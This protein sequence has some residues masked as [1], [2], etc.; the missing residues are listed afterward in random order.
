[1]GTLKGWISQRYFTVQTTLLWTGILIMILGWLMG[2]TPDFT[3]MASMT[4]LHPITAT[5]A[6]FIVAGALKAAGGFEAAAELLKKA[7]QTPLG[8]PFSVIL[9]VNLPIVLAMPC[10]RILVSA[11]IPVALL[12]GRAVLK[13]EKDLFLPA[14]IMFGLTI[15]AA[16]FLRPLSDRWY[17][18]DRGRDGAIFA[19]LF[20]KHTATG[21]R[22]CLRCDNG[23]DKI[24]L[25][26]KR[27]FAH[28]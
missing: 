20:F 14:M 2:K 12:I 16:A 17:W 23:H 27:K 9:L 3:S 28:F 8:I 24:C 15:N 1:M 26:I 10:G 7:S 13:E 4:N 11:L 19:Q 21:H 22:C 25:S 6:G 18:D 5:I